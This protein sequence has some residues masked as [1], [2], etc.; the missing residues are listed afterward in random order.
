[1]TRVDGHFQTTVPARYYAGLPRL[2]AS[3]GINAEEVLETAGISPAK[4]ADPLA[5]LGVAEL[6]RIV[7]CI[8]KIGGQA[9]PLEMGRRIYMGDHA[10]V[11]YGVLSSP[12]IDYALRLITRFFRLVFPAFR[13]RY[14]VLDDKV[15]LDFSSTMAM[16]A[17]CLDFN[18]ELV[19]LAAHTSIKD[20]VQGQL[21]PYVMELSIPAPPHKSRYEQLL[22][23][24]QVHFAAL[25]YPGVRL[26][27]PISILNG[28]P[29]MS[30]NASLMIAEQRCRELMQ[31]IVTNGTVGDWT[32]MMLRDSNDGLPSIE[33]LAATLNVNSR[34][35][36][37]HLKR[38]GLVYRS[39]CVEERHRKAKEL[40]STTHLSVTRI[41]QELG[42]SDTS[43]FIRAF[44]THV[45]SNPSEFRKNT[46]GNP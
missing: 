31:R 40:L 14:S 19:A 22:P 23:R 21:P 30:N 25:P 13:M 1:M 39:L 10:A 9:V 15:E 20:L 6:E 41:A 17:E 28:K 46:Q 42:Y 45:G 16:S 34:T 32:R 26:V 44:R 8:I 5:E 7:S 27:Y 36:H 29:A 4:L 11:G 12:S 3:Q 33:E 2:L 24:V 37:R 43:N 18:I 35:L 38:E